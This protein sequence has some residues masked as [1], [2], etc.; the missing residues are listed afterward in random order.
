[1]ESIALMLLA[2]A[3]IAMAMAEQSMRNVGAGWAIFHREEDREKKKQKST[4]LI[5]FTKIAHHL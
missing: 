2:G 5:E 4:S 3:C 1:M